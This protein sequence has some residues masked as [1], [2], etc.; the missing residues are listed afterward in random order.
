MVVACGGDG[1]S[2][3]ADPAVTDAELELV[4][5]TVTERAEPTIEDARDVEAVGGGTAAFALDLYREVAGAQEGNVIVGPY[6]AWLA[7]AMTSVGA[8]GTTYE[9]L[10][11]A[12]HFPLEEKRLLPAI[13]ALD[14]VVSHR[15]EDSEVT[16]DVANRLWG[17]RG[18]EFRVAFLDALVEHFG[19]PM[20]AADFA[21]DPDG[22]RDQI[23][24]WVADRTDD[25]I[26]ELFPADS[27]DSRTA[28][29]L[30]NAIHLDAPWEF[31]FDPEQTA[32]GPFT[33]L[34]GSIVRTDMMRY[35]QYLPTAL[36][37][38]WRAVEIPYQGGGLSMV[39]IVP[40]D[41]AAFE[42]GLDAESLDALL[43]KIRDGGVHLTIPRFSFSTHASLVEPLQAMGVSSAF[44]AGADFSRMTGGRGLFVGAVEHEAFV[45]VDESGTEAAAAT[46][47]EM[48]GS[49]GPTIVVDRPFIFL[50]RDRATNAILFMGRVMDPTASG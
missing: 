34:D 22:A 2:P 40:N 1:G 20:V 44:G 13:N 33:R 24:G 46:G 32:P 41:F 9:E 35:D 6:S 15:G 11:A 37:G 49:H 10:A 31:S 23:N 47:V 43:G 50:I 7:L 8:A 45:E 17:Q 18:T 21:T 3:G 12:L 27:F 4:T 25:L 48:L 26:P 14:R 19:A 16:F 36:D 42:A 30:V 29:V 38:A 5:A 39:V 28:L